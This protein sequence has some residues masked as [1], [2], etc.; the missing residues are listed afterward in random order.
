MMELTNDS[1]RCTLQRRDDSLIGLDP[2]VSES[3]ESRKDIHVGYQ[4][5]S[6]KKL[7]TLCNI[8]SATI[9]RAHC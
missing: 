4:S 7:A 2:R 5:M 1:V 6:H 9:V 3:I 8:E